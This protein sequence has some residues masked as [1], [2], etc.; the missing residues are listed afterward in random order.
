VFYAELT[1]Q[2][3][4][5]RHY[6]DTPNVTVAVVTFAAVLLL[7]SGLTAVIITVGAVQKWLRVRHHVVH[8]HTFSAAAVI[9]AA[10][11]VVTIFD[12]FGFDPTER[13]FSNFAS[14][15][16]SGIVIYI[17]ELLQV[18]LA[19]F[20]TTAGPGRLRIAAGQPLDHLVEAA[21]IG[22]GFLLAWTLVDWP[23]A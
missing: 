12:K 18:G 4:R 19:V 2:I 16:L 23:I 22:L 14:V 10:H 21:C 9:L 6:L 13:T 7:P 20:L 5:A 1:R 3:E 17:L 11:A 15:A 8:R